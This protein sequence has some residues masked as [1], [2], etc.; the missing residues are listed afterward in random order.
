MWASLARSFELE[1]GDD[2]TVGTID[3]NTKV[4]MNVGIRLKDENPGV[5]VDAVSTANLAA[6]SMILFIGRV[7]GDQKSLKWVDSFRRMY[8]EDQR[9]ARESHKP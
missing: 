8:T 4:E 5:A 2:A 6:F 9:K 1:D 7:F 3:E